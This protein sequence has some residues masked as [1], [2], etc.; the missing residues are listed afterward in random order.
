[1]FITNPEQSFIGKTLGDDYQIEKFLGKGGVSHVF[2]AYDKAL[3]RRV[4]IKIITLRGERAGEWMERFKREGRAIGKL[5]H[6]PNII[7]IHRY[8]TSDSIHYLVMEMIEGE[9]L[10]YQ[11]AQ[12]RYEQRYMSYVNVLQII[13]QVATALDY[14]HQN[15]VIH[16]D[17]KPSNIMMEAQTERAIL[18]DFGLAFNVGGESSP[19]TAFGTPRYM[20]PEQVISARQVSP[21]SDIYSLGIVT[22]E[23]L[24]NETPFDEE[25][26]ISMALSHVNQTT[27]SPRHFR[28]ELSEDV[29]QIILKSLAK[30]PENRYASASDFVD[31]LTTALINESVLSWDHIDTLETFSPQA[32]PDPSITAINSDTPPLSAVAVIPDKAP[33]LLPSDDTFDQ[34]APHRHRLRLLFMAAAMLLCVLLSVWL[35]SRETNKISSNDLPLPIVNITATISPFPPTPTYNPIGSNDGDFL[36]IYN[37]NYLQLFNGSAYAF[38]IRGLRF[39]LPDGKDHFDSFYFGNSTTSNYASGKCVTIGLI[40]QRSTIT[41]PD[42]CREI[43]PALLYTN[44]RQFSFYW[45][46]DLSTTFNTF[47]VILDDPAIDDATLADSSLDDIH[48]ATCDITAHRCTFSLPEARIIQPK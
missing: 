4:A 9:S 31:E 33:I 25:S 18:L 35:L 38:D 36:L 7:T 19:G 8:G 21:Q 6:H 28:P 15:N 40:S 43:K 29:A 13:R 39:A 45:V 30:K 47:Y 44:K 27:P 17:V 16:R 46:W 3:D 48:L 1:M 10:A 12:Y 22:Y 41:T 23:L 32:D 20:A 11:I 2:Q 14:A 42:Y 34:K 37:E 5:S 26:P 24:T